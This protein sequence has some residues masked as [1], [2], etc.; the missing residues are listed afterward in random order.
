VRCLELFA[1]A[2]GAALGLEDAGFDHAGLVERDADACATLRSAG[3]GPVIEAD[4]RDLD[5]IE[6][7][8]FG[9]L[10]ERAWYDAG[11]AL[12]DS[13]LNGD[14]WCLAREDYACNLL[15]ER[16][17]IHLLW[18][19]FPCQA[20]SNAGARLG[21][22]DDRNGW[23]WTVD[24]I[25]R[26]KPQAFIGENVRG[27]LSFDYFQETI[28]SDLSKR[29][30]HVGYW[31]LNAADF[32]VPQHRRR[33]FVWGADRPLVPPARTHGPGMFTKPWVSMGEALQLDG[34]RVVGGGTNPRRPGAA[35]MRTCRDLTDEP[36]TTVAACDING[37][38][39]GPFVLTFGGKQGTKYPRTAEDPASAIDTKGTAYLRSP[40]PTV[41][42]NEVKGHTNPDVDRGRKT[43]VS[44]A[45]DA[46]YLGTGRRRLTV[47]ECAV[48]Q[49]FPP[50]HPFTGTKTSKYRQVGNAVPPKL[51]EVVARTV[52]THT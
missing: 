10:E 4:V 13:P 12:I 23:P 42:A 20:F 47:Q 32:G 25:D 30:K 16:R 17:T 35:H 46:L 38:R 51:A 22:Q 18:S 41:L 27:L 6:Q 1:G 49:N 39:N 48:L 36:S 28:L 5:T 11:E 3:L 33:V 37:N 44:R 50:D 29:F 7:V 8:V 26:F 24:A 14:D 9:K 21:E 45:A 43:P 2:G 34:K 15:A 31:L 40:A 52:L 19:S